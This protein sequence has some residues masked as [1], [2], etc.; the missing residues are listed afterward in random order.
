MVNEGQKFLFKK[1]GISDEMIEQ[2]ELELLQRGLTDYVHN[3][4][5]E[6]RVKLKYLID[7]I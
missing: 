1:I 6:L 7:D 5:F 2:S 4:Q 3:V